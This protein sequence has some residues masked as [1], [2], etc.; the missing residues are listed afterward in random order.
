MKEYK[1][2]IER[3]GKPLSDKDY[4]NKYIESV[5]LIYPNGTW[6]IKDCGSA[7]ISMAIANSRMLGYKTAEDAIGV[8]DE[9]SPCSRVAEIA[10]TFYAQDREVE[11][12]K[13]KLR[14]LDIHEYF[15]GLTFLDSIK[16]PIINPYTDSVLGTLCHGKQ[17]FPSSQLKNILD[18]HGIKFGKHPS[19]KITNNPGKF[20][21][22]EIERDVLFCIC[23]GVNSRKDI[24]CLLSA[25]YKKNVSA[26]TTVNDTF[27]R[28]Y[29]K[30][31]CNSPTQ[32]LAFA[33]YSQLNLQIPKSFF[34][35]G[36]FILS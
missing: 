3:T 17:F 19:M 4:L 14:I 20:K 12:A 11:R 9:N 22:T 5:N 29:E 6:L 36:S 27:R 30:L 33:E 32:L 2:L 26:E 15:T 1:Q 35:T 31:D 28:L 21:L 13:E 24:A 23:L 25:I 16:A 34:P 10:E 18:I 7:I 8:K